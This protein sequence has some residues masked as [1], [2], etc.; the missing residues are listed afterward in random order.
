M[1]RLSVAYLARG[2]SASSPSPRANSDALESL[3][4]DLWIR[5][6]TAY[7][8][9]DVP[10]EAFVAHLARCGAVVAATG[11]SVHAEDLYL[12]C[13]CLRRDEAAIKLLVT[14]TRPML[15]SA[16][17]RID[18]SPAF[19][20]DV[21]QRFWDSVLVGTISTP[22]RL[23]IYSG[24]GALAGWVGVGAQRVALMMRRHEQAEGRARDAAEHGDAA[25]HDPEL[26]FIRD[27]YLD[28]FRAA[29]Q[30]ALDTLDDRERMIF[31]LH[32]V[33]GVT[34]DRIARGY[35]VSHSTVSRWFGSARA[36]VVEE[37]ERVIREEL[38]ISPADF[39]SLK[40][41][42]ISQLDV[43]LSMLSAPGA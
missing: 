11:D 26:A 37:V 20:D 23:S 5:G 12:A 10:D 25:S 39:D 13:A 36:K 28:Q 16:L 18:P 30:K 32:V 3:L 19:V 33:D 34:I 2:G 43:S 31:R 41:L 42:V 6:R 8:D 15:T 14:M 9:F 27:R 1:G 21:Q 38:D 17:S 24:H 29:T 35:G 7:P 22:P 4:H 40:R